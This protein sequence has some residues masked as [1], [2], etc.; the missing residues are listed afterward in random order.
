MKTKKTTPIKKEE[1]V[2]QSADPHIDQDFKGFP[3]APVD[4]ET[5]KAENDEHKIAAG[6][7]KKS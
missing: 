4:K 5:I 1:E 7:I 3:H 6:I 2:Q